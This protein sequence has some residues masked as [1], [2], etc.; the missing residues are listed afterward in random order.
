MAYKI[1]YSP[2]DNHRYPQ[3]KVHMQMHWG[4]WAMLVLLIVVVLGIRIYGA[5]DF[6]IPGDPQVTKEA[7]TMMIEELRKGES[8]YDA[9]TVFCR[10]VL[11]AALC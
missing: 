4:R 2:E 5:P 3:A 9:M 1:Q 6:L 11:D 10:Q 7:A 8:L